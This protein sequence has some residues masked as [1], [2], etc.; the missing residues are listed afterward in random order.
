M[1]QE[2]VSSLNAQLSTLRDQ[3]S[4]AARDRKTVA[5]AGAG[6]KAG[7]GAIA[8]AAD[9]T[10]STLGLNALVEHRYGDLTAT[11]QA[12]ASLAAVNRELAR[13]GQWI[14][15]DPPFGDR[16]TIGGIV[17]TNDSGPRRH[18]FGAPRDNIIGVEIVRADG[19]VAKAGGI[20]VKNVA[21]YDLGRLVTGSFGSLAVIASA[22]FKLYPIPPAS[23]TLVVDASDVAPITAALMASQLT[24]TAIEV[25]THP[26]RLLVR[27]ESIETAAEQQAAQAAD[28]A[29]KQHGAATVVSAAEETALWDAHAQRPWSGDG[30]VVKLTLM[31]VDVGPTIAWLAETLRG[32]DWEAVGRAAVGV[33][34]V[35]IGGDAAHQAHTIAALR[36]RV[37]EGRG[38][39]VVLRASD[40]LKRAVDVWGPAG[41]A[42]PVMRAIKQQFDPAG[43]LNP[44]RGPF[45]L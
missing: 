29:A 30:A 22:T 35:R 11:V 7:W 14:A 26:L 12:G 44:G 43:V 34:L 20:V 39:L 8:P 40:D 41:D 32:V 19:A 33:L 45:G 31:P 17:A 4:T 28:V 5:I 36:A 25:Q 10:I 3:L 9:V 37:P 42:L 23:R 1:S 24:P 2:H 18:R 21:G 38:S 16:A 27:F 13:H 15:L 6:T